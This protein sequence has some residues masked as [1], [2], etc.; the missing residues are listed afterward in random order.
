[1][2]TTIG[3]TPSKRFV[4][5][6]TREGVLFTIE[7]RDGMGQDW[8]EAEAYVLTPDQVGACMFAQERAAEA[9]EINATRAAA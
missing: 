8:R 2:K 1:M 9:Q 5:Q 3:I 4:Y 6:P 7:T